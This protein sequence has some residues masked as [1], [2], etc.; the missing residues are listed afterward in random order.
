MRLVNICVM[1]AFASLVGCA[2]GPSTV[3]PGVNSFGS[4]RVTADDNWTKAPIDATPLARSSSRT[5]T[6]EGLS[7]DRLII[8][9]RVAEGE[10]IFENDS[11]L[12]VMPVFRADM[13]PKETAELVESSIVNLFESGQAVVGSSNLRPQ[14]FGAQSGFM[15]DV[16]AAVPDGTEYRGSVGT[17]VDDNEMFMV[18]FLAADPP[19]YDKYA[20]RADAIIKS[21]TLTVRTTGKF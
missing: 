21:A 2:M 4:M 15:F 11:E 1:L 8:I 3:Q 13:S 5:W 19:Y 7:N 6:Q 18:I 14:G 16:T 17:F 10:S 20:E 9:P 12:A